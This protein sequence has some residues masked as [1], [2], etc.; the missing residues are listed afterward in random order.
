M[1]TR[2]ISRFR[3]LRLTPDR[4]VPGLLAL[5]GILL[6]A[7]R[8]G[9]FT[10]DRHKGYVPLL[11]IAAVAATM[12]LMLLWFLVVLVFRRRFQFSLRLLL[13]LVLVVAI[14]CSWL[15]VEMKAAR[16]AARDCGGNSESRRAGDLRPSGH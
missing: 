7:E 9:W 8:F 3:W 2:S 15:L 4:V 6:L 11:A 13:L 12:A 16:K 10:F 14:P 5:E 1:E